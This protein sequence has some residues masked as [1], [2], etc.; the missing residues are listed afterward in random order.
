M[1]AEA[2]TKQENIHSL[3]P[4]NLDLSGISNTFTEQYLIVYKKTFI[5]SHGGQGRYGDT[6]FVVETTTVEAVSTSCL[7][8]CSRW[9]DGAKPRTRTSDSCSRVVSPSTHPTSPT[10]LTRSS[11]YS[12]CVI[13]SNCSSL[14]NPEKL[15]NHNPTKSPPFYFPTLLCPRSGKLPWKKRLKLQ[16]VKRIRQRVLLTWFFLKTISIL[17]L[18]CQFSV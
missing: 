9:R 13:L 2:Y 16:E 7:W 1:E 14:K 10:C 12:Y 17:A 5:H 3:H 4:T 18:R 11:L 15:H 8:S 6:H